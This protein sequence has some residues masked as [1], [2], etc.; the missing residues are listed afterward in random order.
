MPEVRSRVKHLSLRASCAPGK[1]TRTSCCL[2]WG[3]AIIG[4]FRISPSV[5][6]SES[7]EA[8]SALPTQATVTDALSLWVRSS[9]LRLRMH[10]HRSRTISSHHPV[11]LVPGQA[12]STAPV[13]TSCTALLSGSLVHVL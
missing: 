8:R 3:W 1:A 12:P 4:P 5:T 13:L 10:L 11:W 6:W 9:C 7:E 2:H